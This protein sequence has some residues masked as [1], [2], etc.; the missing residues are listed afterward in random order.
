MQTRECQQQ[1]WGL[2]KAVCQPIPPGRHT[3]AVV[4]FNYRYGRYIH[5][6]A[7]HMLA[8]LELPRS[9]IR[10]ALWKKASHTFAVVL[11]VRQHEYTTHYHPYHDYRF[12]S[13]YRFRINML[14]ILEPGFKAR[15]EALIKAR[16]NEETC[17]VVIMFENKAGLGLGCG[18]FLHKVDEFKI[19]EYPRVSAYSAPTS[20]RRILM[21]KARKN[22]H[23]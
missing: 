9:H 4:R 21:H 1:D 6:L 11:H 5:A 19:N 13:T 15:A 23:N 16:P 2:H 10:H 12:A 8:Y 22:P 14:D 18:C 3:R 7:L 17:V 20:F